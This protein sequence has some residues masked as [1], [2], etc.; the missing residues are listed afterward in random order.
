MNVATTPS[1]MIT[2]SYVNERLHATKSDEQNWA[3]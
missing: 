3:E 2:R 1:L